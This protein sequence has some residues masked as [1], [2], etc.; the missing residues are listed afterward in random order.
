MQIATVMGRW[1]GDSADVV[2]LPLGRALHLKDRTQIL[3]EPFLR[4]VPI[5][6]QAARQTQTQ[7]TNTV[8]YVSD[9]NP[10]WVEFSLMRTIDLTPGAHQDVAQHILEMAERRGPRQSPLNVVPPWPSRDPCY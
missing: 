5:L 6:V 4:D 7:A 3:K 1:P 9:S 2:F 10:H 8:S